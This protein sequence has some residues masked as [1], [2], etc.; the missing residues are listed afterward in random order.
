[1]WDCQIKDRRAQALK[2]AM[3]WA[4]MA[5]LN[6]VSPHSEFPGQLFSS[7]VAMVAI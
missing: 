2:E 4:C 3:E 1:M 6:T 7:L 5:M